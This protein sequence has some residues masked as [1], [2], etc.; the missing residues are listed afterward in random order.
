MS[1]ARPVDASMSILTEV[2]RHPL[3]P[4]YADA[5]AR[6]AAPGYRHPRRARRAAILM[7]AVGLGAATALP[8]LLSSPHGPCSRSRSRIGRPR[9]RRSVRAIRH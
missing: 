9:P 7:V 8:S 2:M 5:S 3:D 1:A 6:K 4:G